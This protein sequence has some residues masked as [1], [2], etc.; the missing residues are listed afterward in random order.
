MDYSLL[1]SP[2]HGI[3]QAGILE[4]VAISSSRGSSQL[5]D[6]SYVSCIAGGFF[7]AEPPWKPNSS[8]EVLAPV[9]LPEFIFPV[10]WGGKTGE[11][12][13]RGT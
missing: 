10:G 5:R 7:T 2:V 8:L 1:G 11:I 12:L 6:R 4:W 9:S 3:S 13:E